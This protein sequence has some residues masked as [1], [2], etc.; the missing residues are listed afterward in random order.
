MFPKSH[1]WAKLALKRPTWQHWDSTVPATSHGKASCLRRHQQLARGHRGPLDVQFLGHGER[2]FLSSQSSQSPP[3][4]GRPTWLA[5]SAAVPRCC[6]SSRRKVC[7]VLLTV[8]CSRC[9]QYHFTWHGEFTSSSLSSP[10][11]ACAQLPGSPRRAGPRA[12]R[13]P[14]SVI[15]SSLSPPRG[16]P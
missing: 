6:S 4:L 9:H 5:R 10:P 1:I 12:R 14:L 2:P 3:P 8:A 7:R 13:A 11:A 15:V 16:G